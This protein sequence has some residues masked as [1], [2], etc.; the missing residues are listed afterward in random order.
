PFVVEGVELDRKVVVLAE[1]RAVAPHVVRDRAL[2]VLIPA[3][4]DRVDEPI[5]VEHPGFGALGNRR[6]FV[7]ILLLKLRNRTDLP[8][9]LLI[10]DAV[11]VKWGVDARRPNDDAGLAHGHHFRIDRNGAAVESQWRPFLSVDGRGDGDNGGDKQRS[12]RPRHDWCI[13]MY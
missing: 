12:G 4:A 8:V 7:R 2:R 1:I 11:D 3:P 9:E 10:E 13:Y 6:A 5:V